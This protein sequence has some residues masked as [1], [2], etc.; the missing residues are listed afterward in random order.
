[1]RAGAEGGGGRGGHRSRARLPP[2]PAPRLCEPPPR[3][4]RRSALA[5]AAVWPR[6][7]LDDPDLHPPA[8]RAPPEARVRASPLGAAPGK[9]LRVCTRMVFFVTLV[10]QALDFR[11]GGGNSRPATPGRDKPLP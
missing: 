9:G 7:H 10:A 3:P 5:A 8:C 11:R 6:R 4:R 1:A 2:C